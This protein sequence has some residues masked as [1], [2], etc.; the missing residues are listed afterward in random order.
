MRLLA[1]LTVL[2]VS[3]TCT[4][5]QPIASLKAK[6]NKTA[7]EP[8]ANPFVRAPKVDKKARTLEPITLVVEDFDEGSVSAVITEM[9]AFKAAGNKNL[10]IKIDSYGGS[11]HWGMKLV[12]EIE[13]Y[14]SPV[15]CVVDTKAMSMG[16][17]TLQS[18]DRRLMTK[19]SQLM[20][21]EPSARIQ[22]TAQEL[23]DEAKS[24]A[25]MADGFI[26]H[27]IAK[28]AITKKGF[29]EK[30]HNKVWYLG[31]EEALKYKAIDDTIAPKDIPS[32]YPVMAA[33][34]DLLKLLGL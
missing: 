19:R 6:D 8:W 1:F 16:F 4:T 11:V 30:I 23:E 14:G 33:P 9:K 15:T 10:W 24:L 3:C 18:C 5:V 13:Q 22:G 29:K 26:E 31:Y 32:V 34:V 20:A 12:Q 17:Y 27:C 7:F 28:M 2:L 21:H 25:V